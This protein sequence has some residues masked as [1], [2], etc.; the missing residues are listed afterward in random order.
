MLTRLG[1]Y[2]WTNPLVF[3]LAPRSQAWCG[4][5]KKNAAR[6]GVPERIAMQLTGHKTRAVFDRYDIVDEADLRE[7]VATLARHLG[8]ASVGGQKGDNR[9]KRAAGGAS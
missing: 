4:V 8:S 9:K 2:G 1:T 7:G 3:S 5:A 6:A